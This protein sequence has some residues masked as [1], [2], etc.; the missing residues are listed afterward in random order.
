MN[1]TSKLTKEE[2]EILK[3]VE[4]GEWRSV[5]NVRAEIDRYQKI[6]RSSLQKNMRVNIRI[7]AMDI[8]GIKHRAF[9]E[10]IPYQT[11]MAS[12]IHKYV[13]GRFVER[14]VSR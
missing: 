1:K 3:S 11:L 8:E 7:S 2:K 10:G 14:G 12:V 13:M 9:Q 6:A 4:K 5:P